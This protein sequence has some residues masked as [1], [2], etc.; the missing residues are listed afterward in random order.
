M[1]QSINNSNKPKGSNI[2][3]N[4]G[5][6]GELQLMQKDFPYL[7]LENVNN[8]NHII[9][10]GYLIFDQFKQQFRIRVE[11][12]NKIHDNNSGNN[13]VKRLSYIPIISNIR[14]EVDQNYF[15]YLI[16]NIQLLN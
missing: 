3:N 12:I 9:Y 5:Y 7:L 13:E 4:N 1:M 2:N 16:C 8:N 10:H 15:K 6:I 11:L 14:L